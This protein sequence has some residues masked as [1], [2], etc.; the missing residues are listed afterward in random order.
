VFALHFRISFRFASRRKE[1]L[2]GRSFPGSFDFEDCSGVGI[3]APIDPLPDRFGSDDEGFLLPFQIEA[4]GIKGGEALR[5]LGIRQGAVNVAADH[6]RQSVCDIVTEEEKEEGNADA[7][8]LKMPIE[9][10]GVTAANARIEI[11]GALLCHVI[12]GGDRLLDKLLRGGRGILDRISIGFQGFQFGPNRR[13]RI[14]IRLSRIELHRWDAGGLDGCRRIPKII[15][16]PCEDVPGKVPCFGCAVPHFLKALDF[17][18]S[19]GLPLIESGKPLDIIRAA[20]VVC[21]VFGIPR[22]ICPDSLAALI[23]RRNSVGRNSAMKGGDL[24][25]KGNQLCPRSGRKPIHRI[26]TA[27][28]MMGGFSGGAGHEFR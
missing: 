9:F 21:D 23:G 12:E 18:R 16:A 2:S 22:P 27:R 4:L 3:E 11:G 26:R 25:L 17:R 24:I 10:Q 8:M 7:R 14:K 13:D 5:P 6:L 28:A 1:R 15:H 19:I 20:S